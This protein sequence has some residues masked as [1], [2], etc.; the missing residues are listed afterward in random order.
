M[1]S[2]IPLSQ[3][4]NTAMKKTYKKMRRK[5]SKKDKLRPW[6]AQATT[7]DPPEEYLHDFHTLRKHVWEFY[8]E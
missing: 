7:E 6:L 8:T 3:N 1:M 2:N 4:V 5:T